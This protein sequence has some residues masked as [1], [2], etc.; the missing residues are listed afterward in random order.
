QRCIVA[1]LVVHR[2]EV[3]VA[4]DCTESAPAGHSTLAIS[5]IADHGRA[6]PLVWRSIPTKKLNGRRSK[7]EQRLRQ[8]RSM[9]PLATKVTILAD[10]GFGNTALFQLIEGLGFS[11]SCASA[12]SVGWSRWMVPA[13]QLRRACRETVEL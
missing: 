7:L 5:M 3:V 1:A 6:T 2:H 11:T 13:L 12:T 9:V 10:R 8:L 4:L